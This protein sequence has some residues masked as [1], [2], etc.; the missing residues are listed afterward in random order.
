MSSSSR[1]VDVPGRSCRRQTY[2]DGQR[3]L[4]DKRKTSDL[5]VCSLALDS[6]SHGL[7]TLNS[8]MRGDLENR[9][10]RRERATEANL[11]WTKKGSYRSLAGL[12]KEAKSPQLSVRPFPSGQC[13]FVLAIYSSSNDDPHC[14]SPTTHLLRCMSPYNTQCLCAEDSHGV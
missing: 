6:E 14:Y 12:W 1:R 2:H 9:P 11:G 4:R 7:Q 3:L 13:V 10:S 5:G 8:C